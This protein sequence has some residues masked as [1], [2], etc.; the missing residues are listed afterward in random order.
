[1]AVGCLAQ[2]LTSPPI[3][4][5]HDDNDKM[6]TAPL[7]F[8]PW[9][10]NLYSTILLQKTAV[11]FR[12]KPRTVK[13][14]LFQVPDRGRTGR[15]VVT[16]YNY[17]TL[18][19]TIR[20]FLINT[21]EAFKHEQVPVWMRPLKETEVEW[22]VVQRIIEEWNRKLAEGDE[23]RLAVERKQQPTFVPELVPE[24]LVAKETRDTERY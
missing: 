5:L 23:N 15:V 18:K 16:L 6:R 14:K 24:R 22:E 12:R 17:H 21:V 3:M 9:M 20:R 1:M 2:E 13:S 7:H 8:T 11:L 4:G 10:T 19:R